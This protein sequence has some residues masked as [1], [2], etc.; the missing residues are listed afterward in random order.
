MPRSL[1]PDSFTRPKVN[2]EIPSSLPSLSVPQLARK[3]S[4]LIDFLL[5][6]V[7][8]FEAKT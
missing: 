4:W 5:K 3:C 8:A 6:S 1:K 2:I 7:G